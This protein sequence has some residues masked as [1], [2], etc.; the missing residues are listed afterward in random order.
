M[1]C[2]RSLPLHALR[3][4]GSSALDVSAELVRRLRA[5]LLLFVH[6]PDSFLV[7]LDHA[8]AYLLGSV[9]VAVLLGAPP[10]STPR[11]TVVCASSSLAALQAHLER[12]QGY[13]VEREL[14]SPFTQY[15]LLLFPSSRFTDAW[16]ALCAAFTVRLPCCGV[17]LKR[18]LALSLWSLW[19]S[20]YTGW[21]H[22]S[23]Q[24]SP[25]FMSTRAGC[26]RCTPNSFRR[27]LR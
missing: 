1:P 7:A 2:L 21:S 18:G 15:E 22:N 10:S 26:V 8:D 24:R 4:L 19:L 13:A 16:S 27:A 20:I 14:H 12:S 3:P 17:Q 25:W 11:L 23:L 9:I 5:A 6:D